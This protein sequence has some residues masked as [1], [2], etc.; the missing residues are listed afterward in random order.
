M[1]SSIS[2][3]KRLSHEI[4]RS[5]KTTELKRKIFDMKKEEIKKFLKDIEIVDEDIKKLNC[6]GKSLLGY[7]KNPHLCKEKSLNTN[8]TATLSNLHDDIQLFEEF[9]NKK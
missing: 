5:Q 4:E 6:N 2:M 7:S 8:T 3:Y 1:L 9:I